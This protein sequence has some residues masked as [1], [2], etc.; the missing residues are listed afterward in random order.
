MRL[1]SLTL[2]NFKG[3][4]NFSLV[5]NGHSANIYGDNGTGK[6]TIFDGFLWLLFGKDSQNKADFAIK[7]L[8]RNGNSLNGIDN[9]VE[10]VFEF[11]GQK[12]ALRKANVEVWKKKNG[13]AE[14]VFTGHEIKYFLN[15]VP[16]KKKEFE[17]KIAEIVE[18][19]TFRLLT[20]PTYFN[21][22]LH[23]KER[24]DILLE[25][26]GGLPDEEVIASN[27][28][29]K[30]LAEVLKTRDIE[31]Y[32]KALQAKKSK[33]NKELEM[34][35]VRIDE[36]YRNIPDV[37]NIDVE[38]LNRQLT[39]LTNQL[40]DKQAELSRIKNGGEVA[41]IE[42]QLRELQSE[43]LRIKNDSQSEKLQQISDQRLL[44]LENKTELQSIISNLQDKERRFAQGREVYEEYQ[45]QIE[46]LRNEFKK[47]NAETL[48]FE[49]QEVCP[50]CGQPMPV[51]RLVEAKEKALAEFN[52]NKVKRLE[53][54]RAKGQA[55]SQRAK[56]MEEELQEYE[57]EIEKLKEQRFSQETQIKEAEAILAKLE[58]TLKNEEVTPELVKLK[59]QEVALKQRVAELKRSSANTIH[60]VES[61]CQHIRKSIADLEAQKAMLEFAKNAEMRIGELKEQQKRLAG[62]YEQIES[63]LFLTDEFIRTKV[64][65]QEEKINSKFS[66]ARFKMFDTQVNGGIVECCETMFEGVPY[67]RGLNNAARINV[68]LDI[69]NTLSRHYGFSAP[70]FIDNRE[71]I[72]DL[73]E[74]DCQLINLIVSEKDKELRVEVEDKSKERIA[75]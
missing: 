73:V 70:I 68:G 64:N 71:S 69:I 63:E 42:K 23:W 43:I 67:S 6:T 32:R 45:K 66:L 54:I 22:Q 19:K 55:L 21:E 8:D 1:I 13:S 3:I 59:A 33:I 49:Q 27:P 35:P 65:L 58:A 50:T 16:V 29:L 44:V 40:E 75:V 2:R 62:E 10:A 4:K 52:Q 34:I 15:D 46:D 28:S 11:N 12:L 53:E 17:A 36:V 37:S 72:T 20:S 41:E 61:E 9:E 7:T 5:L 30:A 47:V 24:R 56:L 39:Y 60:M 25:I 74:T 38:W 51:E 57:R 14:K 26:C 31:E 48:V 18:E